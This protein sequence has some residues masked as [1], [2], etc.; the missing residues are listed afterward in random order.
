RLDH[1]SR[2]ARCSSSSSSSSSTTTTSTNS[3]SSC[4]PCS[5]NNR[6]DPAQEQPVQRLPQTFRS[7]PHAGQVAPVSRQQSG[8]LLRHRSCAASCTLRPWLGSFPASWSLSSRERCSRRASLTGPSSR[9]LLQHAA[10]DRG[11]TRGGRHHCRQRQP[12]VP[13]RRQPAAHSGRAAYHRRH[14]V[15]RQQQQQQ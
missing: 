8:S 6:K 7:T 9:T 4:T 13:Q 15:G 14:H 11:C 12:R 1:G 2:G 5:S 10:Q 3:S